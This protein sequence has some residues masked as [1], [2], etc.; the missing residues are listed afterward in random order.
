MKI[1]YKIISTKIWLFGCILTLCIS[2]TTVAQNVTVSGTVT[3]AETG[4][5]LPG[6]NVIIKGTTTGTSTDTEGAY[7]LTVPSLQDTLVFSFIGYQ[8]KEVPI[9]GRTSLDVIFQPQAIQGE[10]MVVVGYGTQ[11]VKDV[12]GSI[13]IV[14]S[15][16]LNPVAT[17]SVNQMLRG[18]AAG[19]NMRQVSAQPGGDVSVNIRGDI[20]P[21]GG[22]A[23]LYVI[24]GVPITNYSNTTPGLNNNQL[25]FDGGID[26]DPL[27][28]LN[29]SDI[30]SITVLKDAS[31][32]AIYGSAAA[33]GVVLITTKSGKSGDIQVDY[34]GSYTVKTPHEYFPL[35]NAQEFMRQN[36]RL[37]RDQYLFQN[38][39]PPYGDTDP[40]TVPD[41][42]SR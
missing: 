29:P 35:L 22:G 34:R 20:S 8:T 2:M 15:E 1:N 9:N 19:L 21:E 12:T 33:N 25:G 40:S 30:E 13:S 41:F 26:R 28:Y 4:N 7:E 38:R 27:S 6:V 23:P 5:T 18:K 39:L 11:Q 16:D 32:T 3:D 10:E 37:A 42:N 24:D 14:N 36:N 17:S 31:S